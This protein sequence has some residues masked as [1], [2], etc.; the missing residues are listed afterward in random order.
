VTGQYADDPSVG[1]VDQLDGA[2]GAHCQHRSV[3]R[4]RRGSELAGGLDH[5]ISRIASRDGGDA[6][7]WAGLQVV[8]SFD[9]EQGGTIPLASGEGG[10]EQGTSGHADAPQVSA[11]KISGC[12]VGVHKA[13]ATQVGAAEIGVAQVAICQILASEVHLGEI[14]PSWRVLGG[15]VRGSG[16]SPLSHGQRVLLGGLRSPGIG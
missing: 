9:A 6:Q 8:D 3:R 7:L 13:H 11:A 16:A 10:A 14:L 12:E 2:V 1:H 15:I 4:K 5:H